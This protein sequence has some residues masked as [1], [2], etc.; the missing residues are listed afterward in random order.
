[1]VPGFIEKREGDSYVKAFYSNAELVDIRAKAEEDA[2]KRRVATG[3]NGNNPKSSTYLWRRAIIWESKGFPYLMSAIPIEEALR[4]PWFSPLYSNLF[5]GDNIYQPYFGTGSL[6]DDVMALEPEGKTGLGGAGVFGSI[7]SSGTKDTVST[8]RKAT[9]A[10]IKAAG[11]EAVQKAEREVFEKSKTAEGSPN[12]TEYYRRVRAAAEEEARKK[13]VKGTAKVANQADYSKRQELLA[14][15][16]ASRG[17]PEKMREVIAKY[18]SDAKTIAQ[19]P[20]IEMAADALAYLY[21]EVKRLQ[22][23]SH[24][25]VTQYTYRPIASMLNIF[26]SADLEY[27]Q[28]VGKNGV[29]TLERKKDANG[30]PVGT[31]GFHST[32]VGPFSDLAGLVDNPD[33]NIPRLT[34]NGQSFPLATQLDPRPGRRERVEEYANELSSGDSLGVGLRG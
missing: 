19:V 31:P 12:P 32:A 7:S 4:P 1:L 23:D 17:N 8:Y 24:S 30:N 3:G 27:I 5:I 20:D 10:E 22:L 2:R 9:D 28:V 15:I 25:F 21:G 18:S 6:V 33:T 13:K 14:D 11:E 34:I 26:G 16:E 29:G